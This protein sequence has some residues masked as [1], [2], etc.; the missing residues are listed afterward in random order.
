MMTTSQETLQAEDTKPSTQVETKHAGLSL[1]MSKWLMIWLLLLTAG[2]GMSVYW[3]LQSRQGVVLTIKS[4]RS[5]IN[6]VK[7]QQADESSK[8][9]LS[10]QG[11]AALKKHGFELDKQ[12]I[13][14]KQMQQ[15]QASDSLLYQVR[16][17]LELAQMNSYANGPINETSAL[18]TQADKLLTDMHESRLLEVRHVLA[19]EMTKVKAIEAIDYVGLLSQLD[20]AQHLV[21]SLQTKPIPIQEKENTQTEPIKSNK[22]TLSW[23][24]RLAESFNRLKKMVVVRRVD[25]RIEPLITPSLIALLR[26]NIQLTLQEAQLAVLQ[27]DEKLYQLTMKQALEKILQFFDPLDSNTLSLARQLETLKQTRIS[28]EKLTLGQALV[29]LNQLIDAKTA[30]GSKDE[31]GAAL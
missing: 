20:A 29:I 6:A 19:E 23:R 30:T 15:Y 31:T 3:F 27:R 4:L 18:L 26:A 13:A 7:S 25:E 14:L 5:Q 28:Q 8:L 1:T 12:L 21:Y 11:M 10:V 24:E 16:A 22:A 9:D 2:F 17:Y